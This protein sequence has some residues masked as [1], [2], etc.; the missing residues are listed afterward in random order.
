MK[1]AVF[2][3]CSSPQQLLRYRG[4]CLFLHMV[5]TVSW[6][7]SGAQ[8]LSFGMSCAHLPEAIRTTER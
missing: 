5:E 3:V 6:D 7:G 4:V 1:T 8:T 2:V